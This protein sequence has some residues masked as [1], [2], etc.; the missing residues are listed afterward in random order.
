VEV[1]VQATV[2][3]GDWTSPAM[4]DAQPDCVVRLVLLSTGW[5]LES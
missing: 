4:L 2:D 3:D 5:P 1:P